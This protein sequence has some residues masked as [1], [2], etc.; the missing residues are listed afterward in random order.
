[1]HKSLID[2]KFQSIA[3]QMLKKFSF[4]ILFFLPS[5]GHSQ[6][7]NEQFLESLPEEIRKDLITATSGNELNEM[8]QT[9]DYKS[10][11]SKIEKTLENLNGI[12]RFGD[13]FFK[14]SPS[15]FM[16]I[17]DPVANS[18]YILD[19]DD[20]LL[21]Q[22]LGDRS[23]QY[24][25]RIDRSGNISIR[26]VGFI[27]VAGLTLADAN[28]L[29]N[30][31]LSEFFVET[32][33]ILALKEVRDINVLI[34]GYVEKPGFY[35][36][37]GYSNIFH[38]IINSGG[39]S[40]NGSFRNI[41]LFRNGELLKKIDLYR[42]F[43]YG[44]TLL[45]ISLRSG[46]SIVIDP[47][48]NFVPIIGAVNREAIYE[49]REGETVSEL[50]SYAGGFSSISNPKMQFS[51]I[52]EDRDSFKVITSEIKNDIQLKQNDK[53]FVK[54]KEYLRDN[55]F[56][57][58]EEEFINIPVKVNGAVKY[59]GEYY[60][61]QDQKLSEL[62]AQFGGFKDDA[63]IYGAALL[64]NEAKS[65]EEEYNKRLYNDALKSLASIGSLKTID[66]VGVLSD[67]LEEFKKISATGR[68]I[69]EFS[70]EKIGINPSLDYRLSPG[71]EIFVPYKKEI[72]Y[73]FGEVLN[74][75]THIFNED[76][77]INEYIE[78]SG[79]LN[80]FADSAS[81]IIVYPNGSSEKV[82]LRKFSNN[83]VN[84]VP[85][86]VI[87]IPRDLQKVN[88]IEIGSVMAPIISSLAISLASLN[89]IS[90]N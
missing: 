30:S 18:G 61:K 60:I 31:T 54:F 66:N 69:T 75:G 68:V 21:I 1:M 73:I 79:G 36:L 23:E 39:I 33:A 10:F 63:Y 42:A 44:E 37:S 38:A 27:K 26:D 86:S 67:L 62:I 4:L 81:I 7:L 14:N 65:L 78:K 80:D 43:I 48:N 25:Y 40:E 83:N 59:P 85:G 70:L 41:N 24:E 46:D 34:T 71:D 56:L 55:Y 58:E 12:E 29:I 87:Y 84:L 76:I 74:P 15:T 32:E 49:F 5:I 9:K 35:I 17:N 28:K 13:E 50:I 64:N 20:L 53:I 3:V 11:D 88:G 89:S 52:R 8:A 82:R 2:V 77:R 90:N 16:P 51:L 45:D 19:V 6:S 47:S 72:V 57:S 22:L